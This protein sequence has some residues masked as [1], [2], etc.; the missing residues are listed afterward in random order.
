MRLRA[1]PRHA[2]TPVRQPGWLW[3]RIAFR[4]ETL[5]AAL[6]RYFRIPAFIMAAAG[7]VA[8]MSGPTRAAG[9]PPIEAASIKQARTPYHIFMVKSGEESR[10]NELIQTPTTTFALINGKWLSIP[11]DAREREKDLTE[12]AD[13]KKMTCQ[14]VGRD[15]V[16]GQPADHYAAQS[17]TEDG[18]THADVWISA[19]SGLIVKERAVQTEDGKETTTDIRFDYANVQAPSESSPLK[20]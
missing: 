2:L 18:S 12:S 3:H 4:A 13:E 16:E 7:S 6:M 17:T 19:D 10:H 9:C 20:R 5:S 15:D 8:L 14:S 11:H 1:P